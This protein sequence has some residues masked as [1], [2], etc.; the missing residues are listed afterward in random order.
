M[1]SLIIGDSLY[2]I[3]AAYREGAR[4]LRLR[5]P[6]SCNPHRADSAAHDQW[7]YGHGNEAEGEHFR[8][9]VDL[10]E[11]RAAKTHVWEQDPAVPRDG[12]GLVLPDWYTNA[13][14]SKEARHG[15]I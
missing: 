5:I 9:G 1:A 11:T 8:F 3:D 7:N 4:A 6:Y 14:A 15:Q 2:E 12:V 10:I 13:L